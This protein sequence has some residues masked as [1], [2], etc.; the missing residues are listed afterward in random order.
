MGQKFKGAT[1]ESVDFRLVDSTTG[2]AKSGVDVTTLKLQYH[3]PLS[4]AS[5]A[6][7]LTLASALTSSYTAY[8]AKEVDSTNSIGIYRVD[9]PDTAWASGVDEVTVSISGS[10]IETASRTFDLLD[11]VPSVNITQENGAAITNFDGTA[12]AVTSTSITLDSAD[13]QAAFNVIGRSLQIVSATTGA[14]Q[15]ATVTAQASLVA[16]VPTWATTPTGTI[17]YRWADTP[18]TVAIRGNVTVGGYASGQDPATLLLVTPSQLIATDSSNN[19]YANVAKINNQTV[20]ASAAVTVHQ[21]VGTTASSTAQTGDVF[22][23][24]N[25]L[26]S[27]GQF[28]I[29]ALAN[30]PT[31]GFSPDGTASAATAT[32]LTLDTLDAKAAFDVTGF[33]VYIF[34]ATTGKGQWRKITAYNTSTRVATVPTWDVTPTGVVTYRL[35]DPS[36]T[37][38]ALDLTTIVTTRNQ[39]AVTAPNIADCLL[40]AWTKAFAKETEDDVAHSYILYLPGSTSPSRTFT[41]AYNTYGQPTSRT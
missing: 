33:Y 20:T 3:R 10:G 23:L 1:S 32:S 19:V 31:G 4:A 15:W 39:D 28:T 8:R 11:P 26:I 27:S 12:S 25:P 6:T 34:A 41:L 36:A 2:L 18:G 24:V 21:H 14:G 30:A 29:T 38:A 9:V 7:S 16:T 35:N 22:G 5:T 13:P 17:T 37:T 40:G